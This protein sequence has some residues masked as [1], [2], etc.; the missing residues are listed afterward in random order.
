MG[1]FDRF[2]KKPAPGE[3]PAPEAPSDPAKKASLFERFKAGLA[4]T[5]RVLNTDIRD[6]FKKEGRLIDEA[7]LDELFAIMVRT[8]M[9]AGP[10]SEIKNSIATEFRGRVVH[11]KDVLEVIKAKIIE[12]MDQPVSPLVF[13]ESGPTVIMAIGVNGSGKTTSIAKLA[14]LMR[15]EG[16]KVVLGAG[17]TF[18]AAAVQQLTIWGERTGAEVVKGEPNADPAS[19]A[20]RAVARAKEIGADVCILDTAGRLQTQSNLMQ[21]L[22]KIVRVIGK[23]IPE[24]PHEKLLVIDSTA[25]QNGISQ[26]AGFSEAAGGCTGI[27]LT[28]LDGTAKGG[29]V[30]PIR[31]KFN[32]PVKFIG[33]GE[34]DED[35]EVFRVEEFVEALFEDAEK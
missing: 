9:G 13:A 34:K 2:A 10:A 14:S 33:L 21:E 35:L 30:I 31:K 16:K 22:S 11:L 18:R 1:I 4:S 28:K 24:A 23:V 6:L 12:L 8:D 7:F 19:V 26:A 20:H 15:K 25:G 17:D 5:A 27:I 3:Q 29:V 32:L